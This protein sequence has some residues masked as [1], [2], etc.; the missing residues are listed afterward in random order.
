M[1]TKIYNPKQISFVWASVSY[2][3]F[4]ADDFISIERTTPATS[5]SVGAGGEVTVEGSNDKRKQITLILTRSSKD[6][7]ILTAIFQLQEETGNI[8]IA[9]M[10]VKDELGDDLHVAP[11]AWIMNEPNAGYGASSGDLEW[12]FEVAKMPSIH[13]GS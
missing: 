8:F 7:A 12:V 6:N 13:G 2:K 11:E 3:G 9:P 1:A 5:S 4:A 10:T